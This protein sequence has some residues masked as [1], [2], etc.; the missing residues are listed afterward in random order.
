MLVDGTLYTYWTMSKPNFRG[1]LQEAVE[2]RNACAVQF[3]FYKYMPEIRSSEEL[4][5][6]KE[7]NTGV[8]NI[9]LGRFDSGK[10]YF[11]K[12]SLWR[13]FVNWIRRVKHW[14]TV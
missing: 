14:R 1:T 7:T 2:Q 6:M 13:R 5:A 9:L 10:Y 12:P 11:I 3:A 8:G 4:I